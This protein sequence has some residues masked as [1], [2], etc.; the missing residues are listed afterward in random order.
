VNLASIAPEVVSPPAYVVQAFDEAKAVAECRTLVKRRDEAKGEFKDAILALGQKL[1]EARRAMPGVILT[2]GHGGVR[3]SYSLAFLAFVE[4][5]GISRAAASQYMSYA[6]NPLTSVRNKAHY[7]SKNTPKFF[8][9]RKTL[10]EVRELLQQAPDVAT[11]LRVIEE[12][13]NEIK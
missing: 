6:R 11:A 13:L 2:G 12:E 3:E 10:A 4:K 8:Y 7:A 1:I 9:R 5:C